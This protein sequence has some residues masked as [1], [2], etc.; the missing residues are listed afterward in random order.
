MSSTGASE[1]VE[2]EQL[3][4]EVAYWAG[5]ASHGDDQVAKLQADLKALRAECDRRR[6]AREEERRQL[7]RK[8]DT[9]RSRRWEQSLSLVILLIACVLLIAVVVSS[10][11]EQPARAA[12]STSGTCPPCPA[13]LLGSAAAAAVPPMPP[14]IEDE[15]KRMQDKLKR[16]DPEDF[17]GGVLDTSSPHGDRL[18]RLQREMQRRGTDRGGSDGDGHSDGAADGG[19]AQRYADRSLSSQ[20]A[21]AGADL[22]LDPAGDEDEEEHEEEHAEG[23]EES[24]LSQAR[25]AAVTAQEAAQLQA[26]A[27]AAATRDADDQAE[28]DA[29]SSALVA[30]ACAS[31]PC[32]HGGSC[33]APR[34]RA[35]G[36]R[37]MDG[38]RFVEGRGGCP[39]G[40]QPPRPPDISDVAA[41]VKLLCEWCIA[42][43][44]GGYRL[45][46]SGYGGKVE[47]E[48]G[49]P[50][51]DYLCMPIPLAT[52]HAV[53]VD[54]DD[55]TPSYACDCADGWG[56]E[57]CEQDVDECAVLEPCNGG[58]SCFDSTTAAAL[59]ALSKSDDAATAV[60]IGD[61]RCDCPL[62]RR[63][64]HC[65]E[66]APA[67]ATDTERHDDDDDAASRRGHDWKANGAAQRVGGNDG[68]G[69]KRG[70]SSSSRA[71]CA[72]GGVCYTADDAEWS[73]A[74]TTALLTLLEAGELL[75]EHQL[76]EEGDDVAGSRIRRKSVP[77][78][79]CACAAGWLGPRCEDDF[80]E[81]ASNPCLGGGTCVQGRPTDGAKSASAASTSGAAAAGAGA[82]SVPHGS[83][84]CL[85]PEGRGGSRCEITSATDYAADPALWLAESAPSTCGGEMEQDA[86][87]TETETKTETET[88]AAGLTR[89]FGAGGFFDGRGT[90]RG[91]ALPPLGR[92]GRTGDDEPLQPLGL[93]TF[94]FWLRPFSLTH[95][96][97]ALGPGAVLSGLR[98]RRV[99]LSG[100][101][102]ARSDGGGGGG[103]G[104]AGE[105]ELYL[106]DGALIF[107]V[108]GPG[109]GRAD[110]DDTAGQGGGGGRVSHRFAWNVPANS[111]SHVIVSYGAA[112]PSAAGSATSAAGGG[113]GDTTG[114]GSAAQQ[115]QKTPFSLLCHFI[116]TDDHFICQDRLGRSIAR[117]CEGR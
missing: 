117:R 100:S 13:L 12:G 34:T 88:E 28:Q 94:A 8:L 73:T 16:I 6:A 15:L 116:T 110:G 55:D 10:R 91:L 26:K 29:R 21:T 45:S 1:A 44:G 69:E 79:L 66:V 25:E 80:D 84:R 14:P 27:A 101:G 78:V 40:M 3:R 99:I 19:R 50:P 97:T 83:F 64:K 59:S 107:A 23:R 85:C 89:H 81:C 114:G 103:D 24:R 42:A 115:V 57:N 56:G 82:G 36:D 90:S 70:S 71:A 43:L 41:A 111:W 46:G 112:L 52:S 75:P 37:G 68:A 108:A 48:T 93:V 65:D 11:L 98:P 77:G 38:W 5:H 17:G 102:G 60:G 2:V 76:Q 30:Q 33:V 18:G 49:D 58:A 72:N 74:A 62:G 4:A 9:E 109:P 67:C 86:T 96:P 47:L 39:P 113:G 104:G 63:G 54:G 22:L 35:T 87:E 20:W 95:S 53:G 61:Y 7:L 51:G 92:R 106:E 31:T 32:M 105:P